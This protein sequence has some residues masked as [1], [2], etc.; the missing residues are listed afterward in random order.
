[1][2]FTVGQEVFYLEDGGAAARIAEK[3]L[4]VIAAAHA[5]GS[6][7][8]N[9]DHALYS[10]ANRGHRVDAQHVPASLV[11]LAAH[12]CTDCKRAFPGSGELV[13][14]MVEQCWEGAACEKEA[15]RSGC[16]RAARLSLLL[17][18]QIAWVLVAV[19]LVPVGATGTYRVFWP[20][21]GL[22]FGATT[23]P[24]FCV[25]VA[26]FLLLG[27]LYFYLTRDQFMRAHRS[28]KGTGP[29]F[30]GPGLWHF[31][32]AL[33][34]LHM[35][36]VNSMCVT[37]GLRNGLLWCCVFIPVGFNLLARLPPCAR[38]KFLH[39]AFSDPRTDGECTAIDIF[40]GWIPIAFFHIFW[41]PCVMH[42]ILKR[43]PAL[44]P[45]LDVGQVKWG[46]R[47]LAGRR[48]LFDHQQPCPAVT[49][50]NA[51]ACPYPA[52][53]GSSEKGRCPRGVGRERGCGARGGG[54]A[55]WQGRSGRCRVASRRESGGVCRSAA[56]TRRWQR[57]LVVVGR[58]R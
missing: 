19:F 54:A 56:H 21:D 12:V 49:R 36:F 46:S 41:F 52:H 8:F 25:A 1:M 14:H 23:L 28:W 22:P 32:G 10:G 7:D 16:F 53:T 11:S 39:A 33:G 18:L 37:H 31:Y 40:F 17:A 4:G 47:S 13:R 2:E 50:A 20:A 43:S 55:G 5:D 27:F 48:T 9:Y 26:I 6:Y 3:F 57:H 38:R 44:W 51:S 58:R 24:V 29:W 35:V 42:A 34:H 45:S 30:Q 15:A